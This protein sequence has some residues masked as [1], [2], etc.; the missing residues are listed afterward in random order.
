MRFNILIGGK[1]GQGINLLA[2]MLSKILVLNG[3]RIFNERDYPSLIA[4]GNNF[5][6]V[7]FSDGE[8]NSNDNEMDL[9]VGLDDE[10]LMKHNREMKKDTRIISLSKDINI[11]ASEIM[12][13]NNL[14][15]KVLNTVFL[16]AIVKVLGLGLE[17]A[18]NAI[19]SQLNKFVEENRKAFGLGYNAVDK[20]YSFKKIKSEKYS[21]LTGSEGVGI[22]AIASGLD[23]YLAYPM[24]PATPLLN[25]LLTKQ[26]EYDFFVFMPENEIA[27][28]NAGL[29]ASFA[30]A[31][32]MVGTSGGGFDLMTEALSLQGIS[33]LPF[34]VYL[35]QR[36]GPGTGVPT[37]TMQGDLH[38]ALKCSHGE[39]PRV[40]IAPGDALE[41]IEKT[42]EGFYLSQKYR[43]GSIIMSDKHL[44]ESQYC[45]N[46]KPKLK[47]AA[48]I[49]PKKSSG[50]FKNYQITENGLSDR[51]IP[52]VNLVKASSYEHDEYGFTVESAES[53]KRMIEK[54]KKKTETLNNEVK[55][56]ERTKV[57]GNK[58]SRT[59]LIGWGSTK[60]ALVDYTNMSKNVKFLQ[61]LYL[62]PFPSEEVKRE[63]E[64]ADR[65]YVVENNV[66]GQL[67]DL[68]AEK[69]GRIIEEKE[70]ILKYDGRPFT[71]EDIKRMIEEK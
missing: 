46:K 26:K 35:A 55:N 61:V 64:N 38:D 66:T 69:T 6:I 39:F 3:Y 20:V 8:V 13:K 19:K 42:N 32:S 59:L 63:I 52:G 62:E 37:Y 65:I 12:Q 56:F 36:P 18:E 51:G 34:V 50:V 21:I 68:I 23:V 54:R 28:A 31:V 43:I 29:G 11:N 53:V 30:G 70:R 47:D 49:K 17:D 4:G 14:N 9:I 15:Q 57:Y 27:V 60:G 16:G 71:P 40:V 10:T 45:F 44:A 58:K 5:N 48:R 22:G 25:Y 1:A 2:D 24:T 41:A 67:A 33:E 7:C